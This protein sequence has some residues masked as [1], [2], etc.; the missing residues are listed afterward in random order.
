MFL[1]RLFRRKCKVRK[2]II[3][4]Q[5]F[6][7]NLFYDYFQILQAYNI[8]N[9]FNED[10][11]FQSLSPR[12]KLKILHLLCDFRLDG[13]E[14]NNIKADCLRIEPLGFDEHGSTYWYFYGTRLYREDFLSISEKKKRRKLDPNASDTIWQVICFTEDDWKNLAAKLEKSTNRRARA[15]YNILKVNFLPKIP[16]LFKEKERQ[17]RRK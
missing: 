3:F 10:T 14:L 13:A 1:R 7:I 4:F 11:D 12:T 2:K 15:L 6:Y 16:S 9:P 5:R 17:R 8:E